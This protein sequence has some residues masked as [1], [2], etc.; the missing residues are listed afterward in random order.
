MK[1]R[2]IILTLALC[3]V[4]VAVCFAEDANMGT[5]KLN[6]TKSMLGPRGA[7]EQHGCLRGRRLQRE[8]HGGWYRQRR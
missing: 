1:T 2:T 6:E 5:W 7:E 4:G 3:L 8:S